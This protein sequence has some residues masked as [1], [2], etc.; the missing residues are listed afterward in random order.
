MFVYAC[1]Y[2][3]IC[4]EARRQLAWIVV[5]LLLC[6]FLGSNAGFKV[7]WSCLY[8]PTH[9]SVHNIWTLVCFI[10]HSWVTR[11]EWVVPLSIVLSLQ[12]LSLFKCSF[13]QVLKISLIL[14][15]SFTATKLSVYKHWHTEDEY[16]TLR[17]DEWGVI[18]P[19][20]SLYL[21][22]NAH[23]SGCYYKILWTMWQKTNTLGFLQFR[24]CK[25]PIS[26]ETMICFLERIS[27]L[28]SILLCSTG[29][30]LSLD[31]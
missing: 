29:Y 2:H 27:F 11:P 3:D 8:I 7:W 12:F 25:W 30:G 5:L 4:V 17:H 15:L 26:R 10:D 1:T 23:F 28:E 21:F 14:S 18:Y 9:L 31:C 19:L 24:R 6:A 16:E 20:Y 13:I 22:S